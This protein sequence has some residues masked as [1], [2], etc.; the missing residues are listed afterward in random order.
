VNNYKNA[1][2]LGYG[3]KGLQHYHN[4]NN[5][6]ENP[7]ETEFPMSHT[8]C[9]SSKATIFHNHWSKDQINSNNNFVIP[10]AC[11]DKEVFSEEE[12]ITLVDH[13][14]RK[15]EKE[16]DEIYDWLLRVYKYK[17]KT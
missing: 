11:F 17:Q 10:L 3:E 13:L 16:N 1:L 15:I 14:S 7:N 6:I 9:N 2:E 12:R 5:G 8:V 4:V